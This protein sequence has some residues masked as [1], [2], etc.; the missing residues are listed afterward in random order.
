MPENNNPVNS[1]PVKITED[2]VKQATQ[3]ALGEYSKGINDPYVVGRGMP[4]NA[5]KAGIDRYTTY[6]SETFGKLGFNPYEDNL[7][8]Y[9]D[10]TGAGTDISRALVGAWKLAKISASD[11]ILLGASA[12]KDSYKDFEKVMQDYSSTRDGQSD[13]WANTILSAGYTAGIIGTVA[14]EE[15]GLAAITAASGLTSSA[16]TIPLM[17]GSLAKG[18]S[19]LG[20][21]GQIGKTTKAGK[22][23][24]ALY[25]LSDVSKATTYLG[26]FGRGFVKGSLPLGNTMDF[27]KGVDKVQDINGLAQLSTGVGALVR[28]ARKFTMTHSESAMEANMARD[29]YM[30]EQYDNWY[31]NNDKD[32]TDSD[33]NNINIGA[34]KVFNSTYNQNAGLIYLSNSLLFDNMLKSSALTKNWFK[35]KDFGQL[36]FAR[37]AA[38]EV[39]VDVLK[40]GLKTWARKN[41]GSQFTWGN[42][43]DKTLSNSIEGI[44]ETAQDIISNSAKSYY[45]VTNLGKQT[46]GGYLSTLNDNLQ[47]QFS[48]E[49][50]QTFLSGALMG[51]IA[52]PVGVA[53]ELVTQSTVGGGLKNQFNKY[54]NS[55]EWNK[56]E[57]SKYD[58]LKKR[59]DLLTIFF[60]DQKNYQDEINKPFF[61]QANIQEKILDA[62]SKGDKKTLEDLKYESFGVG[63]ENLLRYDM[64]DEFVGHL[65]YMANNFTVDQ[66]NQAFKRNDIT[67]NNK[68]EFQQKLKNRVDQVKQLKQNYDEVNDTVINPISISNLK[69]TDKNYLNNLFKYNA[70]E[71]L[72]RELVLAKGTIQD[73][74]ARMKDLMNKMNSEAPLSSTDLFSLV[75]FKSLT[76]QLDLLKNEV[77]INKDLKKSEQGTINY[78]ASVKKYEALVNYRK[79]LNKYNKLQKSA[80]PNVRINI[81]EVYQEMFDAF[82][83]Y[84]TVSADYS[85][86]GLTEFGTENGTAQ[87]V[88]N[89]RIFDSL[90]DYITLDQES[91]QYQTLVNTLLDP[92]STTAY[93]ESNIALQERFEA[94]KKEHIFELLKAFEDKKQASAMLNILHQKGVFFNLDEI[95]ALIKDGIMPS[96]IYDLATNAPASKEKQQVAQ[97]V[98]NKFYKNLTGKSILTKQKYRKQGFKFQSDKRTVAQILTQYGVKVGDVLDLSNE[99]QIKSLIRKITKSKFLTPVDKDV[100]LALLNAPVEQLTGIDLK[101]KIVDNAELP[102]SIDADGNVLIDIRYSGSDYKYGNLTFENLIVS[103][104]TQ[105]KI[106]ES[107]ANNPILKDNVA[108]LMQQAKEQYKKLYPRFDVENEPIF[109][110]P[111]L[112]LSEALNNSVF[113]SQLN[114]MVNTVE[115]TQ[116]SLWRSL[117]AAIKSSLNALIKQKSLLNEALKL[118]TTAIKPEAVAN[119]TEPAVSEP[120]A[121]VEPQVDVQ[122]DDS[123]I[124]A[125]EPVIPLWKQKENLNQAIA[126]KNA[127]IIVLSEQLTKL[128]GLFS[129]RKRSA[130]NRD[131][132]KLTWEL[133]DLQN[134]LNDIQGQ[135]ETVRDEDNLN[136]I[137]TQIIPEIIEYDIDG[138]ILINHKTPFKYFTNDLKEAL[139]KLYGKELNQLTDADKNEIQ[140]LL[141]TKYDY[142]KAVY[143]YLNEVEDYYNELAKQNAELAKQGKQQVSAN[144]ADYKKQKTQVNKGKK[145]VKTG[146]DTKEDLQKALKDIVDLSIFTNK[147]IDD[148]IAK[149]K[150]RTALIKFT[151]KDV[152][153]L[154]TAKKIQ[155]NDKAELDFLKELYKE[156]VAALNAKEEAER[157][158]LGEKIKQE[159]IRQA[160]EKS[161]ELRMRK[162][163]REENAVIRKNTAV[164]YAGGT[165]IAKKDLR[166]AIMYNADKFRLPEKEFLIAM[167]NVRKA[168]NA[169]TKQYSNF[170]FKTDDIKTELLNEIKKLNSQG[171][172]YPGVVYYINKALYSAN[173]PLL[174]RMI[175]TSTAI[176][177]AGFQPLTYNY[178][179][180]NR[181]TLKAPIKKGVNAYQKKKLELLNYEGAADELN[182]MVMFA[183]KMGTN[184]EFLKNKKRR[185]DAL[186]DE[187]FEEVR[188][189]EFGEGSYASDFRFGDVIEDIY[190]KYD[191]LRELV[192]DLYSMIYEDYIS[193]EEW[194]EQN[195]IEISNAQ[196][197]KEQDDEVERINFYNSDAGKKILEDYNNELEKYNNSEAFNISN[198]LYTGDTENLSEVEQD[199]YDQAYE[200]GLY[201][202]ELIPYE[203]LEPKKEEEVKLTENKENSLIDSQVEMLFKEGATYDNLSDFLKSIY[204]NATT[205]YRSDIVYHLAILKFINSL[206][207]NSA[208]KETA[209]LV[210]TIKSNISNDMYLDQFVILNGQL[211][212]IDVAT[213]KEINV[214]NLNNNEASLM[215][216]SD[217]LSSFENLVEQNKEFKKLNINTVVSDQEI[218]YIKDAYFNIFNNFTSYISSTSEMTDDELKNQIIDKFKTCT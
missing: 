189:K 68:A 71:N 174:V 62:A 210:N 124:S 185:Y 169:T 200:E 53:T 173:Y 33:I 36:S 96:E 211:Y 153:E 176:K 41:V 120:V 8:K 48:Q 20:K 22:A 126:E 54:F 167:K 38:G 94:N 143:D 83:D 19:A 105:K 1:E 194:D 171:L 90:F 164:Y 175:P 201:E 129:F 17:A 40:N 31:K 110:D 140:I 131:L 16:G 25:D 107:I 151:L 112:F 165:K 47:K 199:L 135:F 141:L 133:E 18:I 212:M 198:G 76:Q 100:L 150:D 30:K 37:N 149:L 117:Y 118:A 92:D 81:D 145:K 195:R 57:T 196:L 69:K 147:E 82:N 75:D 73:K 14:A 34:D 50:L 182:V 45:D 202:E 154:A 218:D 77:E 21:L 63:V 23:L 84:A 138:K 101:L 24:N 7:K 79:A 180:V 187:L 156:K 51:T 148:I 97:D 160:R 158:A 116:K 163:L 204:T 91:R 217:F 139:A 67:E 2:F 161:Y 5:E 13:F 108:N 12:H 193:L 109:N 162:L 61:R 159:K 115:P 60:N 137:S 74:A 127:K 178:D 144:F 168:I 172:L 214:I 166:H 27:I 98:I 46:R 213:D 123:N 157:I 10:V 177:K 58:A 209:L 207:N 56:Q 85:K 80:D 208:T 188:N 186:G 155:I 125:T 88:T 152:I 86:L 191:S 192:E 184:Q 146:L 29:S 32:M 65:N 78:N 39:S 26:K 136:V 111:N 205:T 35:I 4:L 113:Q 216:I 142:Q 132:T 89:R 121:Q 66:L 72:K 9:N 215:S 114:E 104:I 42:L 181:K 59:A 206:K 93:I 103:A 15:I 99:R 197:Q 170:K 119:I 203:T 183:N 130:I 43:I 3:N 106:A 179:I 64:Q 11:N 28:D 44:Q 190:S 134:Q 128:E 52:S 70:F 49:G 95:D 122:V 6:G 102:I 87:R 55:K